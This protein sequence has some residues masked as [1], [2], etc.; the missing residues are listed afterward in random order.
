MPVR[1]TNFIFSCSTRHLTRSLRSLKRT[2]KDKI[3][4]HAR[5]YNILYILSL[6]FIKIDA[7]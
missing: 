2:L 7:L 3:R 6:A 4:I 1:G 5:A